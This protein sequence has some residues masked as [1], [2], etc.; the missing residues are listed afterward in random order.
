VPDEGLPRATATPKSMPPR[1]RLSFVLLLLPPLSQGQRV[2]VGDGQGH[3]FTYTAERDA[4][5]TTGGLP[6][7][8][9]AA[10]R[11]CKAQ[12]LA[13][14][15]DTCTQFVVTQATQKVVQA[16]AAQGGGGS[17]GQSGSQS[18]SLLDPARGLAPGLMAYQA[19]QAAQSR[20]HD[21]GDAPTSREVHAD[22]S[23]RLAWS[24][25]L[26]HLPGFV[27]PETCAELIRIATPL[28]APSQAKDTTKGRQLH[29]NSSSA[30]LG[31][32]QELTDPLI[33]RLTE[34]IHHLMNLPPDHGEGLQVAHYLPG[35]S[36]GFHEDAFDGAPRAY[37]FLAFL[38]TPEGGGETIFPLL[39]ANG[40]S[41][42]VDPATFEGERKT[43]PDLMTSFCQGDAH[44]NIMRIQPKQGD[45][46]LF[47]PMR[48][49]MQTDERAL[50]GACHVTHGEKWVVQRW[51]RHVYDPSYTRTYTQ[52]FN[53]KGGS[54]TRE[55]HE[56]NHEEL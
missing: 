28:L 16:R 43:D 6:G 48:P 52:A 10:R 19:G 12:Q 1:L 7:L 35:Q 9:Q 13:V 20:F 39:S 8:S 31:R 38:N 53:E 33:N 32:Q 55:L 2:E 42:S 54:D 11:W 26:V 24:P 25:S 44:R 34:R 45:A 47:T 49:W 56:G 3:T 40:S 15:L 27:D 37:T 36:Y 29:R 41:G 4:P 23:V 22:R 14:S 46:I 18:S 21:S 51:A 5:L 30:M 17:T 50:H